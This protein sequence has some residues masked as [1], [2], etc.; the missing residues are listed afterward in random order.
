M[1]TDIPQKEFTVHF[2]SDDNRTEV[3]QFTFSEFS[4]DDQETIYNLIHKECS[5]VYAP[6]FHVVVRDNEKSTIYRGSWLFGNVVGL[7]KIQ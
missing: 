7:R 6:T 2:Y 1:Y 3:E 5:T 4:I